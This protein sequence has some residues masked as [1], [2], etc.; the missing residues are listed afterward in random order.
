MTDPNLPQRRIERLERL[1]R[2]LVPN[3]RGMRVV[4]EYITDPSYTAKSGDGDRTINAPF[5]SVLI[6]CEGLPEFLYGLSSTMLI[7]GGPPFAAR[8]D[9]LD[10]IS[11][12]ESVLLVK[13]RAARER[14]RA[15][16]RAR[17]A[18]VDRAHAVIEEIDG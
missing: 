3:T 7:A 6:D 2:H 11:G 12:V 1:I 15:E 16:L 8:K 18:L 9:L 14:V 4:I 13:L 5:F 10:A 17:E